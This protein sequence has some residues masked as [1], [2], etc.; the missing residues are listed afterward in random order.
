MVDPTVLRMLQPTCSTLVESYI[1][2]IN[3]SQPTSIALED[4]QIFEGAALGT[5]LVE[6]VLENVINAQLPPC[7]TFVENVNPHSNAATTS[8]EE[9]PLNANQ[10]NKEVINLSES[11]LG[12]TSCSKVVERYHT[13]AQIN[14]QIL[15]KNQGTIPLPLNNANHSFAHILDTKEKTTGV[16]LREISTKEEEVRK[17]D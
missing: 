13:I 7:A 3:G 9:L 2:D 14:A 11:Q 4:H 12:A 10:P 15:P 8:S 6:Q 17:L 16:A 5:V 1:E